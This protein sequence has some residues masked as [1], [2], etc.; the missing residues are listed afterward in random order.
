MLLAPFFHSGKKMYEH[1]LRTEYPAEHKADQTEMDNGYSCTDAYRIL[2]FAIC[3]GLSFHQNLIRHNPFR[4]T[5][6]SHRKCFQNNEI[7]SFH[8][9]AANDLTFLYALSNHPFFLMPACS[10]LLAALCFHAARL[11]LHNN[12]VR[13]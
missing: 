11:N 8:L 9:I 7:S 12:V 1:K 5:I 10:T 3:P 4:R 6:P 13:S 2:P